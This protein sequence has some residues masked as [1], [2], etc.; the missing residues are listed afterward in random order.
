MPILRRRLPGVRFYAVGSKPPAEI[1][2]L[3][4]EWSAPRISSHW[5]V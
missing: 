4:S 5:L 2:A 3:A 1:Q